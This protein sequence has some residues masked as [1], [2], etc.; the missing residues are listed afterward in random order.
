MQRPITT[1]TAILAALLTVLLAAAP[2]A[3]AEVP[4]G[5][6]LDLARA[7]ATAR[8][9]AR[10]VAAAEARHAASLERVDEA[11]GYRWPTVRLQEIWMRT[12]SPAEAFALTLNQER[13]SFPA[14]VAG[15]PN[16]PDPVESATTRLEM[17]LPL[18]TGGELAA[19]VRQAEL[20]AEATGAEAGR[21]ADAAALAAAEAW[22]MLSQAREQ[23]GLLERSLA[24]VEAHVELARA[25]VDQGMLVRSELLR[26]EVERARIADLLEAARGGARVARAALAFR[27]GAEGDPPDWRLAPVPPPDGGPAPL[28]DWLTTVADRPDLEAARRR[29]RA[30]ELEIE[31]KQAARLPRVGL[32]VR[33]DLVDDSPFGDHGDSTAVIAQGSLDLWAGGRHRAAVAAAEADAESAREQ[34]ALFAEAVRLQVREAWVNA[35]SARRRHATAHDALE[36]ARENERIVEER[37]R[38]GV[39]RTIDLLDAATA[40]REAETRELVARADAQ[41]AALR[42]AVAAGEPPESVLTP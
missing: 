21:S 33:G 24:T 20:A 16:A 15:D 9:R 29:A 36:A 18:Y 32:V 31:V 38:R 42:L 35:D 26:A 6:S 12:D 23:S 37:F 14:F 27:L 7:M 34:V 25:Y 13:F 41:L 19:R 39:A 11:R 2:A 4:D 22:L 40:R 28:E 5:G 17:E 10:E 3:A 1:P 30:A 8:D